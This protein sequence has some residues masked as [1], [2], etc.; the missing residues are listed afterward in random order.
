M[1]LTVFS[2]ALKA[3]NLNFISLVFSEKTVPNH[4]AAKQR[5]KVTYFYLTEKDRLFKLAGLATLVLV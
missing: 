3:Q 1:Y 4:Y 5:D 2:V